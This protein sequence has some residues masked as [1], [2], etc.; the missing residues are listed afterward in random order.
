MAHALIAYL[1]LMSTDAADL[2]T[3]RDAHEALVA[4]NGNDREQAHAAAIGAWLAGDWT[5]AARRLDD[6]LVHWPARHAGADARAPARL[7]PRRRPEP[8]RPPD[9]VAARARPRPPARAVR[10]RHGGVRARGV[11]P[12]RARPRHRF[13]CGRGQRRR[14]LGDP[15]RR[16]HLRDAGQGRRGH[17]LPAIG[18]HTVGVRQPVHRPQLVAPRALRARGR[19][20]RTRH[21]PSTTPRST[22]TASLGVPIEMLDAS[23]LLWR[24]L[25]DGIDTGATLRPARRLVGAEGGDLAVVRLQRPARDDGVG[26]RRSPRRGA[27]RGRRA[28]PLARHGV[29]HERAD[30]GRDRAAGMPRRASR[31]ASSATAT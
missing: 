8:A 30:D 11:R 7:L 13:G 26:R 23:A 20:S 31:S 12:L 18:P 3:A 1:H 6:L 4:S 14:R 10:A 22:T 28:R 29:R 24:M 17:R 9:P 19:A 2:A 16:P 5:G 25:L 15:R 27:R 21:S